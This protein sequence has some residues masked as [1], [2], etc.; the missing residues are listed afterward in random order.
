MEELRRKLHDCIKTH[1]VESVETLIVSRE[2]DILVVKEQYS[3]LKNRE[4]QY[5]TVLA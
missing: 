2:L 3:R 5:S 4:N 1:G